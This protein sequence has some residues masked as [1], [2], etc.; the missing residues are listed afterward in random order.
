MAEAAKKSTTRS[1]PTPIQQMTRRHRETFREM[2]R[3]YTLNGDDAFDGPEYEA[4]AYEAMDL[5]SWIVNTLAKSPGDVAA[6]RRFIRD[7]GF[8]EDNGYLGRL[9]G[10]ILQLDGAAVGPIT[11]SEP[12]IQMAAAAA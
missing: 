4:V 12:V 11:T 3:L 5:E 1:S 9:M 10:R 2:D 6:K 7:M 8:F